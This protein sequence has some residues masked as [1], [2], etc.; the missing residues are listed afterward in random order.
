V[1]AGDGLTLRVLGPSQTRLEALKP[2]WE[3]VVVAATGEEGVYQVPPG[4]EE[5]VS[6]SP[7]I[8]DDVTDVAILA[9]KSACSS[10]CHWRP[11]GCLS[12]DLSDRWR[13]EAGEAR[14]GGLT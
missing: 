5:L 4:L 8:L 11:V 2:H 3:A 14:Q 10:R 12:A 1:D 7:P 6:S 13:T 9:E